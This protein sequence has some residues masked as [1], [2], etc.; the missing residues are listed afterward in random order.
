MMQANDVPAGVDI[1]TASP[2]RIY[3]YVLGGQH[4][5]PIDQVAAERLRAQMPDL[6]DAAWANRGFRGRAAVWMA[7]HGLRQF[8]DIG[9]G[10]PLANNTHQ[11]VRRIAPGTRVAYVDI[12]PMMSV[13]D[14][15]LRA[16]NDITAAIQ[17]DLRDPDSVLGSPA[18]RALI[19]FAEPVGLLLTGV[20]H[21]VA[22]SSDPWGLVRRYSGA[23]APASYLALS[24]ATADQ[25]AP[26]LVQRGIEVYDRAGLGFYPRSRAQVAR[27]FDRLELVPPWAGA[28]PALTYAG[29]WG[30]EDLA[31]AD[32]EGSRA[33]YCGV[34]RRPDAGPDAVRTLNGHRKGAEK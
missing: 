8:L 10:L 24:H 15:E 34:A 17:A 11:S 3:D 32:S 23:L 6:A 20:L 5:F 14:G 12:D 9:C 1:T 4:N 22:D 26:R 25:L 30:A 13:L 31:A 28:E 27:F 29:L 33:L 21:F 18:I 2:A 7:R 16:G 19:D